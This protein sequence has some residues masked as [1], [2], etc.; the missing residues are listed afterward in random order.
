MRQEPNAAAT[1]SE[2]AL[3]TPEKEIIISVLN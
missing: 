2:M 1:D 3:Y